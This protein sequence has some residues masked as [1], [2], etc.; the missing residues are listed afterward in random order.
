[1]KTRR[2]KP[3]PVRSSN[4]TAAALLFAN[5]EAYIEDIL[6]LIA[7]YNEIRDGL[8]DLGYVGT[9]DDPEAQVPYLELIGSGGCGNVMIRDASDLEPFWKTGPIAARGPIGIP[10]MPMAAQRARLGKESGW[11]CHY[12][13][14]K[15]CEQFGPDQRIW[16]V[17]HSYPVI[18]GGDNQKDNLVLACA[19]CNLQKHA[20]T[21]LEYFR[22]RP[23]PGDTK[24]ETA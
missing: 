5:A 9:A 23:I 16:R 13:H 7:E 3:T 11:K 24:E 21:A 2:Q 12:C 6:S 19:T 18:R 22:Q 10:R 8:A 4:S 20:A 1:M 15:G 17:D 14:S